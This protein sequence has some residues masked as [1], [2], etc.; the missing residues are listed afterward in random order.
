MTTAENSRLGWAPGTFEL[1]RK[2][3]VNKIQEGLKNGKNMSR[4]V[5]ELNKFIFDEYGK[6]ISKNKK[7]YSIVGNKLKT[8]LISEAKT[9]TNVLDNIL[10]SWLLNQNHLK[11]F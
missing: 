9:K 1:T 2:R 3:S 11:F 7:P 8:G 4:E 10:M 5:N 6:N